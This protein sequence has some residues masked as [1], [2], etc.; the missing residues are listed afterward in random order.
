MRQGIAK[1]PAA[2]TSGYSAWPTTALALALAL[3][4]GLGLGL[5]LG[6]ELEL[7]LELELTPSTTKHFFLATQGDAH[8][9]ANRVLRTA[10]S[11]KKCMAFLSSRPSGALG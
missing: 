1:S 7:E 4:L 2:W 10:G 5:R 11:R 3:G 9:D 8:I 6:L